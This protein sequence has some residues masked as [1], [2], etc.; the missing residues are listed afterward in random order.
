MIRFADIH[1][2]PAVR[3]IWKTC[4]G[5]TEEFIDLI[6]GKQ[7]KPE[8]TLLFFDN[9]IP[10]ASLH[11]FPYSISFYGENVPF[12]YLAGLATLPDYRNK[13]Y[14]GQLME[15]SFEV[16]KER[17]IPLSILVPAEDSLIGY[18]NR[19]HFE[20]VFEKSENPLPSIKEIVDKNES[21]EQ[22]YQEF[23]RLFNQKNLT[24]QKTLADFKDIITDAEMDGFPD[25]YNL[26]GMA[27]IIDADYM[28]EVYR[29]STDLIIHERRNERLLCRLLF[30][31][32]I[33]KL[34]PIYKIFPGENPT[35]NLMLE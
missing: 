9:G 12:Y 34:P 2:L 32:K 7:Y 13:G 26:T 27:K 20:Q 15:R 25:K 6:F 35:I 8:N 14:M 24:V 10:V 30:G 16:M 4:F 1:T 23:D 3:Q 31:Y 22:A 5:D 11:M 19:F 29:K 33:D 17:H 28:K 21:F 18:Y